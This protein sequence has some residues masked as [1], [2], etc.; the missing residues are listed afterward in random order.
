MCSENQYARIVSKVGSGLPTVPVSASHN[1]GDWLATDIYE[2]EL[3]ID[4]DTGKIYTRL[5]S[6]IVD[7]GVVSSTNIYNTDGALPTGITRDF[8]LDTGRLRLLNGKLYINTTGITGGAF[9]AEIVSSTSGLIIASA[10]TGIQLSGGAGTCLSI[11]GTGTGVFS[12]VPS[13]VIQ[14]S[15]SMPPVV[16]SS[17][18][19]V[20]STTQGARPVP[21]LTESERDAIASPADY[22]EIINT[23]RERKEIYRPFWGWHPVGA[24]TPDWGYEM[25][26]EITNVTP[27]AGFVQSQLNG[28]T[29]VILA[30]STLSPGQLLGLS[31][32][33]NNNGESSHLSA[34]YYLGGVGKKYYKTKVTHSAL[35]TVTDRFVTLSG[36]NTATSGLSFVDGMFF[37]YD[38][39]GVFGTAT[40][41]PNWLCVTRNGA[42]ANIVDSGVAV[43]TTS[44]AM[45]TLEI[46]EDGTDSSCIF[47]ING[48]TVYTATTGIPNSS[49]VMCIGERIMKQTGTTARILYPDFTYTKEKFNT[50]R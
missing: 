12:S 8:N 39:G 18:L 25:N 11:A 33:V 17:V 42:A 29:R 45:Q 31:T 3:Y 24:I 46:L 50:P 7:I 14:T 21:R 38:E 6:G 13:N 9:Q 5:A 22:L 20:N 34:L 44:S 30:N 19:D 36:Y 2:G 28:G 16:P 26:D 48:V 23:T 47:K 40:A 4:S 35:S 41:S 15:G 43:T 10:S 32:G 1:D 37:L 27:N 49:D